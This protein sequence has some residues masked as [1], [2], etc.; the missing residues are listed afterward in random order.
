MRPAEGSQIVEQ[1]IAKKADVNAGTNVSFP[2]K[3]ETIFKGS[4]PLMAALENLH[5]EIAEM[6]ISKGANVNQCNENGST[7]LMIA[8]TKKDIKTL[9][10][11]IDKG[12]KVN[13]ETTYPFT[14]KG[15][16][17]FADSTALMGALAYNR[18][19]N[20]NLLIDHGANIKARNKSGGDALMI[21]A[22]ACDADMV[23]TLLEKG[24]DPKNAI[25]QDFTYKGLPVF[26]G[27]TALM[28][29]AD[30]G[31][32]DSVTAL[33]KAGADP[34]AT[35][36]VG[37]TALMAAAAKGHLAAVEALVAGGA[38][39]DARTTERFQLGQDIVP[40]GSSA[41]SGAA[42]GGHADVVQFLIK[43]GADVNSRD[44]EF[45]VDP[46]F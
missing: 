39:I 14:Y 8:A 24:A 40:K 15:D 45:L 22:S 34:N 11:L 33:I 5:P 36:K 6:L 12:A 27:S 21:A 19:E 43:N 46:L 3:G 42:Y 4:T 25:T 1:L 10:T 29:A 18:K 20:A 13:T 37:A 32:A 28:G 31:N 9:Q 38:K 17:V 35:N 41:I 44:D 16:T 30:A 2:Y 7:P 26:I 23:K